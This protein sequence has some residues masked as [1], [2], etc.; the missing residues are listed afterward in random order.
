MG[1]VSWEDEQEPPCMPG[2]AHE[3]H[4][5]STQA[6]LLGYCKQQARGG[7]RREN[8]REGGRR[9]RI[10]SDNIGTRSDRIG[11]GGGEGEEG[12]V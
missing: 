9:R 3:A 10:G 6:S 5:A 11:S 12:G 4:V 1:K 8:R 7:G 2:E